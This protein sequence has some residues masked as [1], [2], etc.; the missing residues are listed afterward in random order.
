MNASMSTL[1]D[2]EYS[3]LSYY[4]QLSLPPNTSA[5]DY[6]ERRDAPDKLPTNPYFNS[7]NDVHRLV[8]RYISRIMLGCYNNTE[9]ERILLDERTRP[10]SIPGSYGLAGPCYRDGDYDFATI[11]VLQLL[12]VSKEYNNSMPEELYASL[13]DKLLTIYGSVPG[14]GTTYQA[15]CTIDF[16]RTSVLLEFEDT[17]NHILQTEISR[18]LTN[19][20]LLE[21]Y[22][23]E[24]IYN[25]TLNGNRNWMLEHLSIFLHTYFYEYN[26]RPYQ[27][28]TVRALSVLYSYAYDNDIALAAEMILDLITAQSSIQM[29]NLRRFA[30]YRRQPRYENVTQSWPGDGE[31]YRL[32]ILVGRYAVLD[33][34][35]YTL[36]EFTYENLGN[37]ILVNTVA[38]KYRLKDFLL[39]MF[40]RD[41]NE[42]E[43]YVGNHD[44]TEMY[45]SGK[46]VL[47]SAGGHS[48]Q[49]EVTTVKFAKRFCFF[50][51]CLIEGTTIRKIL[52]WLFVSIDEG[53]RGF[54]RPTTIVPSVEHSMDIRDMM[55]FDGHRDP[56]KVS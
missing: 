54:S 55:R 31:F 35:S 29:N 11:D 36:P 8:S 28:F 37:H 49:G 52:E 6:P 2:R 50:Q 39:K 10:F 18:Y 32:S 30:P 42:P 26:A 1:R 23:N 19:Q 21:K 24:T 44:V 14:T 51:P 47:I 53:G 15:E 27:L 22:P 46:N 16:I 41:D 43:Y 20:L 5:D 4:A 9:I 38:S 12:Y 25:N 17:E 56:T 40:F 3:I 33:G 34:P 48:V 7:R 45:Y 13:R